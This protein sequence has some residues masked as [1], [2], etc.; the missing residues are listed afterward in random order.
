MPDRRQLAAGMHGALAK[1]TT[2]LGLPA[3]VVPGRPKTSLLDPYFTR[4]GVSG[5][6]D[7]FFLETLVASNLLPCEVPAVVAHEWGHLAGLARESDASF[8]G[9]VV[10]LQGGDAARYSAW[11]DVFERTLPARG[12]ED[13]RAA[14][15]RLPEGVRADL[16][17][18]AERSARDQVRAVSEAAWRT[19]DTYLRAQRVESGVR[20]YGEV[21]RL[22]A[23]TRFEAGWVPV[24][25]Q[26]R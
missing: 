23:G 24:L 16:R 1:G 14:V 7:P 26:S 19:Y 18:M 15:A 22:L 5:M 10:C 2:L 21:V 8:F 11:L 20:N 25:K 12:R 9:I 6:T 13:R 4:A 17:A 3:P